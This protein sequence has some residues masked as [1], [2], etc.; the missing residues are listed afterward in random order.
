MPAPTKR[1]SAFYPDEVVARARANAGASDWAAGVQQDVIAR[2]RPWLEAS[3]EELWGFMFGPTIPRSWM[4]WSDGICPACQK[5]VKMYTWRM[6]PWEF[7]WKV[8][9][10]HCKEW[11]PKNDFGAFYESG[12]DEH[13]VFQP[14]RADRALLFNTEHP[15]PDDPLHGFGVDDGEGY[16]DAEGRR[17]RFIGAY[18]I[19]GQ[20][21]RLIVQGIVDLSAAYVATGDSR[22]AYKAALMLDRVADV[23]PGFDFGEQG[24]VYERK[25]DRGQVSTWHDA[26]AEVHQLALAYDRLFEGA[27]DEEAAL[28]AFLSEKARTHKLDNPKQSWADIQRNIE[29][30]VFRDTLAHGDRIQSNYPTTDV[31]LMLIK[32]VLEW[33]GNRDEVMALMDGV[34]DKATAVDGMS[35]EKGLA[36]YTVIAP[37]TLA[38]LLAQFSLLGPDFLKDVYARHPALH[39]AYRF[40]I[41]MWCMDEWYPQSGDT[42]SFAKKAPSYAGVSLSKTPGVAPSMWTFLWDMYGLTKDAA[43]VQVM[44]NANGATVEGLPYDLFAEDPAAMQAGVQAVIDE[45]GPAIR[46]GSVNKPQW[47]IAVLRSGEAGLRRALWLDYDA[48]GAHGH[49]D[50]MNLGF[51]GKGLDL[52]PDFGYPPVG[53]G[54]WGS[55]KAL[56]YRMTAAHN[57]VVV[58]GRNQDGAGGTT[59]LWADGERFRCIRANAP[60][61]YGIQRYERLAA[62]VDLDERDSYIMDCFFVA[63]GAEH[64][65]FI[66][67]AFGTVTTQGLTLAPAPDYGNDTQMRNFQCDANAPVGWQADWRIEDRRNYLEDGADI[68]VRYTDLTPHTEAGLAEAWIDAAGFAGEPTW[69]PQLMVRRRTAEGPL[70]SAFVSVIEPYEGT[71]RLAAIRRLPLESMNARAMPDSFVGVEITRADGRQDVWITVEG[72]GPVE[73]VEPEHDVHVCGELAVLTFSPKGL[74][75][76]VLG[77]CQWLR[78]GALNVMLKPGTEFV[79]L[80]PGHG[81][82]VVVSGDIEAVEY[83]TIDEREIPLSGE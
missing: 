30:R 7:R 48:G 15:D 79:E 3:D 67:S 6:D 63:G 69:I 35:G 40:H 78:A 34:I 23:F 64:A 18:L 83:V 13:G 46:R 54:G 14:A 82:M 56:W 25:G 59:T 68:H 33:P 10:P 36:G 70:V 65:K 29:D 52:L 4:V 5:D 57:T 42:G 27:R 37:R 32:A 72:R 39:E 62:L 11:F 60:E 31:A 20:W 8:Q 61:M 51:F 77:N 12:L 28:V 21:K 44:Y 58:D 43:F 50:G 76:I 66:H 26:C 71:S 74:E 16:V 38:E 24:I 49:Q 2:A 9:C 53:Y 19:Y 75:R 17:W 47:R 81:G 73:M 45:A 41:D 22:Y 80:V 55:P 1:A